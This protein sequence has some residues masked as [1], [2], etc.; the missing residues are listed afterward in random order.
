[1]AAGIADSSLKS[2][3]RLQQHLRSVEALARAGD[4]KRA[5]K[6]ADEAVAQ[7]FEHPN[8]LTLATYEQINR[9]QFEQALAT[10]SRARE[11]APRSADALNAV[12]LA[13]ARLNRP[14]E[15]V[16]AYDAALRQ[17]PGAAHVHFNRACAFEAMNDLT[18]ARNAFERVIGL[19]PSHTEALARLAGLAAQRG[20]VSA[21][22]DY[23][24]RS[25]KHDPRGVAAPLALA[26][27]D[28]EEKK[29][30]A[31]LRQLAPLARDGNPSLLNRS[32]AQGLT[33][34]ALD[35]LDRC[36]E[37]FAMYQASGAS[38][39]QL[40]RPMYEGPGMETAAH[41]IARL[42]A[43]FE[44]AAAEAWRAHKGALYEAPVRTHVF[45]VGF[46][47]SGTTLLE[48]VLDSHPDI[49]AMQ[50]RDCL[51]DAANEFLLPEGG[52][53]R[54]AGLDETV[55]GKFRALYWQRV[56]EHG[57][58]PSKPVFVDKMPL[59]A[60]L[61]CL[62]AKLFPEA[63]ILFALRDPRDA[64]LSSFRRRFGLTPQMYE[65]LTLD[66]AARYYDSVM[67]LAEFYRAKLGLDIHDLR[68]EDMVGDFESEMK[69]LCAFLG[70]EWSAAMADFAQR[71]RAKDVNTPS[72]AQV[73]RGLY[74]QAVGQW[75]RYAAQLS[76]VL[77]LLAPWVA[78]F[79]YAET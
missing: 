67:R 18:R 71:A 79:G 17:E 63:K 78:R 32:I 64:V 20:D 34:D 12:G 31:A 11:L 50:E 7:G 59:N 33:A 65:L 45:L 46:P 1:M 74:S 3:A 66:G 75:R 14:R 61:L 58:S 53:D 38:L 55:A 27:A 56:A 77:P 62:V 23:A 48:Q 41:R 42:I 19:Q 73:A 37:A 57:L 8:L 51:I 39:K 47:R 24:Q 13:L 44:T 15:A 29:F 40:Y 70:V 9:G 28:I 54:L 36:A 25:L 52:L 49:E 26:L 21:A 16:P 72:A 4:M 2:P 30:E 69:K 22:R 6:A 60:V 5:M 68:Y 10:A 43:Y 35:G 76:P